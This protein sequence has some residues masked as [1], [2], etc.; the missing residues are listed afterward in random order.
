[1][2][3]AAIGKRSA[4]GQLGNIFDVF[5]PHAARI[6][7]TDIREELVELHILLAMSLSQVVEL[8]AG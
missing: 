1:M 4:A 7:N 5:S 8:H 2:R 6:V 3:Y